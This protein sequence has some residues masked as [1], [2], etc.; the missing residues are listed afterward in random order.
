MTET[1]RI[2]VIGD[3]KVESYNRYKIIEDDVQE[4]TDEW[5]LAIWGTIPHRAFEQLAAEIAK[6]L[7]VEFDD[8]YTVHN[9]LVGACHDAMAR[10]DDV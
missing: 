10:R 7:P 6:Q 3:R 9:A 8:R 4:I 2:T 5:L 1:Y